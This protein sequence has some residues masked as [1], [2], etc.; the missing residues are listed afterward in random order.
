MYKRN[1]LWFGVIL[2][3]LLV[4]LYFANGMLK[5]LTKLHTTD[6]VARQQAGYQEKAKAGQNQ[7]Q[8]K[9]P[10]VFIHGWKGSE[11]TFGPMIRRLQKK[12]SGLSDPQIIRIDAKNKITVSGKPTPGR[13][14]LFQIVFSDSEGTIQQQIR[15]LNAAFHYLKKN[16]HITRMNVVSHSLGGVAFTSWLEQKGTSGNDPETVSF[17]PIAAPFDGAIGQVKEIRT[18]Y[19]NRSRIPAGMK[20]LAIAGVVKNKEQGD[21]QVSLQSALAGKNLFRAKNYHEKVIYGTLASHSKLHENAKVDQFVADFLWKG[22]IS[23]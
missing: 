5:G 17:I 23:K 2:I 4:S 21:G 16:E 19:P 14:P 8:Q 3:I 11:K 7:A 9:V 18:L 22:R 13:A 20:V 12:T 15:W 10:V 1:F 6:V